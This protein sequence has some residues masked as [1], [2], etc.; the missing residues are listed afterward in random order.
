MVWLSCGKH[1]DCKGEIKVYIK[2][3]LYLISRK[4]VKKLSFFKLAG[5]TFCYLRLIGSQHKCQQ[6]AICACSSRTSVCH[7]PGLNATAQPSPPA[8]ETWRLEFNY[9][10]IWLNQRDWKVKANVPGGEAVLGMHTPSWHVRAGEASNVLFLGWHWF[11]FIKCWADWERI[12]KSWVQKMNLKAFFF[13]LSQ[14]CSSYIPPWTSPPPPQFS[15]LI[16][17]SYF[18]SLEHIVWKLRDYRGQRESGTRFQ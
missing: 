10:V 12:T 4:Q 14:S 17:L 15:S 6:H 3:T 8:L 18:E 13:S 2:N 1:L 11:C 16:P 7:L 9:M 5:S